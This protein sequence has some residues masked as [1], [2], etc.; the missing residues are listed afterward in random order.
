[1]KNSILN[2]FGTHIDLNYTGNT[3]QI[4]IYFLVFFRLTGRVRSVTR[5]LRDTCSDESI[6]FQYR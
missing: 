2:T 4:S 1:M 5:P 3:H 6:Y